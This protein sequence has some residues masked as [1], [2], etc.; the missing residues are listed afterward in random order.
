LE[1][2]PTS[3]AGIRYKVREDVIPRYR[4]NDLGEWTDNLEYVEDQLDFYLSQEIAN[5]QVLPGQT[6]DYAGFV[7][8]NND[9][10]IRQVAYTINTDGTAVSKVTRNVE[11][12]DMS[13]SFGETKKRISL[14]VARQEAERERMKRPKR[15]EAKPPGGNG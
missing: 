12:Y 1:V 11:R 5:F 8:L 2:D 7:P 4:K 6:A 15:R 3:P 10:A 9:G 13:L 14:A